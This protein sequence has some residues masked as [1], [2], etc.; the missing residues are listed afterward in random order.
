MGALQPV[1][2]ALD[3]LNK[4]LPALPKNT[5]NTIAQFAAWASLVGAA[6]LGYIAFKRWDNIQD[7]N[8]A[9][10]QI[11]AMRDSAGIFGSYI[12]N[13]ASSELGTSA[14]K[15][16]ILFACA[17]LGTGL[18]IAAFFK[19]QKFAKQGWDFA[20]LGVLASLAYVIAFL[21]I[22][23]FEFGEIFLHLLVTLAGLYVVLQIKD[24]YTGKEKVVLAPQAP[25]PPTQTPPQA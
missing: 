12:S 20:L 13:Y 1:E 15:M 7:I 23:E 16:W 5:K 8:N 4:K 11:D 25:T 14:T 18:F 9:Q 6:L 21:I 2:S 24:Y 19:L 10:S 22:S 3:T 17:A